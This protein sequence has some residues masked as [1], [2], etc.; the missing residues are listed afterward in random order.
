MYSMHVLTLKASCTACA[1]QQSTTVQ[2]TD[3]AFIAKG[4]KLLLLLCC[5]VELSKCGDPA[6]R[7]LRRT[8]LKG[9]AANA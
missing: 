7:L 5:S 8:G 6:L 3:I 1:T 4:E 9:H 2:A